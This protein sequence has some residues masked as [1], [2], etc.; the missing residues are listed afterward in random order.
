MWELEEKAINEEIRTTFEMW[1]RK[2][3]EGNGKN[4]LINE[5]DRINYDKYGNN[6][7]KTII[8]EIKELLTYESG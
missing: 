2:R 4:S 7:K 8:E 5:G 3:S 1:K 6:K